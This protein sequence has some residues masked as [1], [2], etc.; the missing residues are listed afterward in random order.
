[1]K[2]STLKKSKKK[3]MEPVVKPALHVQHKKTAPSPLPSEELIEDAPPP[4]G[5]TP[6]PPVIAVPPP[7]DNA[8]HH[9]AATLLGVNA[10]DVLGLHWSELVK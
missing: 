6:P 3:S 5:N 8:P 10:S 9:L 7:E 1:M 2:T 4:S